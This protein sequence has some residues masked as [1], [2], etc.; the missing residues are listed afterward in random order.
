[1]GDLLFIND[2]FPKDWVS[3]FVGRDDEYLKAPSDSL[4]ASFFNELFNLDFVYTP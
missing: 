4:K 1:M 3:F 2:L